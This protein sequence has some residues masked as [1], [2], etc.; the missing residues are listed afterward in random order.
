MNGSKSLRRHLL[1]KIVHIADFYYPE[2][3]GGGELN[4]HELISLLRES[5]IEVLC[6]KSQDITISFLDSNSESFYIISN[7]LALK[8][9]VK[10]H[11]T[12]NCKYLIYEHDHK[13]LKNRNPAA[14]KNYEA[15]NSEIINKQFYKK[16]KKVLV[17]SCFHETIINKNLKLD[18]V[19]SVSGNLWSLE[20][21][22][23]L[24]RLA[25]K[26][27]KQVCSIL[28]SP[29][30]HKNSLTVVN[31]CKVKNIPYELIKSFEYEEFL[32]MLSENESFMFL[33][34]TPETL[35]RIVVEAKMM[36]IKVIT[37]KNVGAS[38]EDWFNQSGKELIETMK[39]KRTEITELIVEV[40]NE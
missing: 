20:S 15:P 10:N 17:Q 38:H 25:T 4:N 2:V 13:Y 5:G 21:L 36:G 32:Q 22:K 27:K 11:I 12:Q 31:Y 6:L 30:K 1:S 3:L 24:E 34:K 8:A 35:S 29:I 40:T 7:F 26:Q 23:L 18:N 33:P 9:E 14:Y 39:K 16:A 28:D 37:N 19:V